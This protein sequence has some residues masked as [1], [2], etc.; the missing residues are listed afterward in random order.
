MS[1]SVLSEAVEVKND[2]GAEDGPRD[3]G[4]EGGEADSSPSG[5]DRTPLPTHQGRVLSGE[6][7]R[8]D[9]GGNHPPGL[10]EGKGCG[11]PGV[12]VVQP[13]TRPS[14]KTDTDK[15]P[16]AESV[17]GVLSSAPC[18][19]ELADSPADPH[20]KTDTDKTPSGAAVE[21][22]LFSGRQD[23]FV[24]KVLDLFSGTECHDDGSGRG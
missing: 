5:S 19:T 9:H 23:P 1:V 21:G 17:D 24:Q 8:A 10:E 15:T 12:V 11:S 7:V 13:H 6:P 20:D 22:V 18:A 4:T 16:S 3:A 2:G 14:D